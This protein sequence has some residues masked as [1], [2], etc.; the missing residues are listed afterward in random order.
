MSTNSNTHRSN[1]F[2]SKNSVKNADVQTTQVQ[3]PSLAFHSHKKPPTRSVKLNTASNERSSPAMGQRKNMLLKQTQAAPR[4]D[5]T[6]DDTGDDTGY[7]ADEDNNNDTSD[8]DSEDEDD[9]SDSSASSEGPPRS[10]FPDRS[11]NRCRHASS[12][13]F[14]YVGDCEAFSQSDASG[15][16]SS[17]AFSEEDGST[18]K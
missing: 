11:T 4:T 9:D 13:I 12:R 3:Q 14:M 10:V 8:S 18:D 16:G 2:P 6:G 7:Y 15:N 17:F 5:Q 1:P